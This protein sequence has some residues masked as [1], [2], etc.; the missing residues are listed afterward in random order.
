MQSTRRLIRELVQLF[1]DDLEREVEGVALSGFVAVRVHESRGVT[2]HD[3]LAA[4]WQSE[5]VELTEQEPVCPVIP[6]RAL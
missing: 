5:L 1:F 3:V 6:L 2:W 4:T